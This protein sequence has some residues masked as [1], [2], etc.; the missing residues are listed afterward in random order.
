M[1]DAGKIISELA[2]PVAVTIIG[3]LLLRRVEG[4]KTEA[5]RQSY[6]Q[7]KWAEQF[8]DCCQNFLCTIERVLALLTYISHQK[9][10]NDDL[11]TE[12]QKEIAHLYPKIIELELRI[13]RSVVF[14]PL[15]GSDAKNSSQLHPAVHTPKC[16]GLFPLSLRSNTMAQHSKKVK[17]LYFLRFPYNPL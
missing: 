15:I 8:F 7:T 14:A 13:R 3:V 6:F 11:G 4:I 12:L 5:S 16:S 2:T 10:P 17:G 9:N 1:V